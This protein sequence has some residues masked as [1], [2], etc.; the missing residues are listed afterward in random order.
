MS[1]PI[2]ETWTSADG[3]ISPEWEGD[4]RDS[5]AGCWH[6]I[7]GNWNSTTGD[8]DHCR[9]PCVAGTRYCEQHQREA[10]R[11]PLLEPERLRQRSLI[12]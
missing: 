3:Q 8:E 1:N 9:K 5:K 7:N 12:V 6:V 11:H 10:A 2:R 4:T